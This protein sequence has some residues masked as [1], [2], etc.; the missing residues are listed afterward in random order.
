MDISFYG[1]LLTTIATKVFI[2]YFTPKKTSIKLF[3]FLVL[4]KQNERHH[5]LTLSL[6]HTHCSFF[7]GALKIHIFVSIA[8]FPPFS[9]P[10]YFT[11]ISSGVL[12]AVHWKLCTR[13]CPILAALKH[14][15]YWS[16]VDITKPRFS[17]DIAFSQ[18]SLKRSFSAR[19][20]G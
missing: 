17:L 14:S 15:L 18:K 16:Y 12:V 7:F 6:S 19:W 4:Y 8:T 11:L 10:W 2:N 20:T 9:F 1:Y 5:L 13:S 3:H